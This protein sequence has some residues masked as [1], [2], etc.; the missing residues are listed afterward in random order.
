MY[1]NIIIILLIFLNQIH[2]LFRG[3]GIYLTWIIND[4]TKSLNFSIYLFAKHVT[5]FIV[6]LFVMYPKNINKNLLL[7]VI[8]ISFLDIVFFVT[9][10]NHQIGLIKFG[11]SALIF[12]TLK[13]KFNKWVKY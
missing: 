5:V 2:T 12:F 3:C 10:S 8:I 9:N 1:K 13:S 11:L 4:I 6:L 7:M